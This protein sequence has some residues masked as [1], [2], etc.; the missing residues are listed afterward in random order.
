MSKIKGKHIYIL[1]SL[2]IFLFL[3]TNC[4]KKSTEPD[5]QK[6]SS[7]TW[8]FAPPSSESLDAFEMNE[9]IGRGFNMGNALEAP[10]EGE[11]GVVIQDDYFKIIADTG[12]NSIRLPVTWPTRSQS[13]SPFT[14]DPEFFNRVDHIIQEAL[15]NGLVVILNNHH[16][17]ELNEDPQANKEWLLKIW[18][19]VALHFSHYPDELYFEILNEPHGAFNQNATIWNDMAK[20]ALSLVRKTNPYRM[21]V[22]GP[23]NWNS[24]HSLNTL[25]LPEDDR[26]IIVTYHFYDPFQFTHQGASWAGD[27]ANQ[28]LGTKWVGSPQEKKE[29]TD[30][31]DRAVDWAIQQNRPLFMGEF[32]SYSNADENS[33]YRWTDFVSRSAEKRNISWTYWE[34]CAGFGAYDRDKNEWR[35]LLLKA[36]MPD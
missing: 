32:G 6:S 36:L 27:E 7:N 16:F 34:F 22:L 28:W 21:V 8:P 15:K 14:I 33:R 24:I 10:S 30:V 19:Q 31:M 26:G 9:K 23:I 20:E 12:F 4:T 13:T 3:H 25:K 11:W 2:V 17:D 18:E 29:I 35:P 1:F 5:K